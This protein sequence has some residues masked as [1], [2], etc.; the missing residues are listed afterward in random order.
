MNISKLFNSVGTQLAIARAQVE[1]APGVRLLDGCRKTGTGGRPIRS[2]SGPASTG[3]TAC[4]TSSANASSRPCEKRR[5]SRGY[6]HDD[7][8]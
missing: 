8:N 3:C 1:G 6:G 7:A 5:S 2:R 4:T